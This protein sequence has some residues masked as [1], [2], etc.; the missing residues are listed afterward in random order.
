VITGSWR[1][2]VQVEDAD[3]YASYV[4]DTG[5]TEYAETLG[6]A[7]PGMRLWCWLVD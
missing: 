7:T 5:F 1:G 3:A 6:N 2:V 4:R